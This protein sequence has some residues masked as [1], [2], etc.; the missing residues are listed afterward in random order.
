M[1]AG[2]RGARPSSASTPSS[3]RSSSAAKPPR[4]PARGPDETGLKVRRRPSPDEVL[5]SLRQFRGRLKPEDF[6][7]GVRFFCEVRDLTLETHD[8]GRAV[9]ERYRLSVCD[10]MIVAAALQ[11]GCDTLYSEEMQHGLVIEDQLQVID[12]FR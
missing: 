4:S 2:S 10:S 3:R 1:I 5:A 7:E 6:H 9:G 11:A 12:P 8:I